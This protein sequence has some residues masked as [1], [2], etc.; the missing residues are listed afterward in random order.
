[1]DNKSL[2]NE[3]QK[4]LLKIIYQAFLEIRIFG[5]RGDAQ[6]CSDL[7]NA[8]HN[9]PLQMIHRDAI[10]MEWDLLLK[11]IEWYQ[12]KY[13]DFEQISSEDYLDLFEQLLK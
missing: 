13:S 9:I 1:M 5:A 7:A 2:T 11:Y 10:T 12:Q 4:I 3:Q 8:V 6:R